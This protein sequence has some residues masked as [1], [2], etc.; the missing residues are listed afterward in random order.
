[1]SYGLSPRAFR[2]KGLRAL[3]RMSDRQHAIFCAVRFD[4][5]SYVELANRHGISVGEV[6]AELIQALII[7][8]RTL[9]KP[10]PWWCRFWPW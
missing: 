6:E 4:D 3:R 9:R 5:A 1:M 10:E 8:S 2:R 7:L